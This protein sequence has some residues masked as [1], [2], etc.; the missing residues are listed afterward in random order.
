MKISLQYAGLAAAILL[1]SCSG[2]STSLL[3]AGAPGGPA[4][5]VPGSTQRVPDGWSAT[6]TQAVPFNNSQPEAY[7][8]RRSCTWSSACACVMGPAPRNCSVR[9]TLGAAQS[10]TS[11]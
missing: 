6:A 11:G 7:R 9:N 5:S 4:A 2:N 10:F 3:P 8:M 1:A